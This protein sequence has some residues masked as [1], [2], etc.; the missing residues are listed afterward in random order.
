MPIKVTSRFATVR[1]TAHVLGV[2]K[3][4]TNQLIEIVE[5]SL[6]H[7]AAQA[8]N[9]RSAARVSIKRKTFK[10]IGDAHLKAKWLNKTWENSQGEALVRNR[11]S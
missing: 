8:S 11:F 2:S 6:G 4:R 5:R 10:R 1:D 9:E 7:R 3:R